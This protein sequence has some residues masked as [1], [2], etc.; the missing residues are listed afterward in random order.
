MEE[1]E[2]APGWWP[3]L[4]QDG[5]EEAGAE[6]LD[7]LGR[8]AAVIAVV[9]LLLQGVGLHVWQ[10][11]VAW[12]EGAGGAA[13]RVLSVCQPWLGDRQHSAPCQARWGLGA[14]AE[15]EP[16]GARLRGLGRWAA[17]VRAA[18]SPGFCTGLSVSSPG[19]DA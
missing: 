9:S 5:K 19:A 16:P 13:G 2:G 12:E 6:L 15:P 7:A 18:L 1:G 14:H 8:H 3:H 10:L 11:P 4:N 17:T